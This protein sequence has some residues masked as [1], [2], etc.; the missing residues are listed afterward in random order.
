V[1]SG[2]YGAPV[3]LGDPE[4]DAERFKAASPIAQVHRITRPLLMANGGADLRV[5]LVHGTNRIDFW[6]KVE[7]FL[8][9]HIGGGARWCDNV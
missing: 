4:Q 9:K 3:L 6:T 1:V 5:P 8:G 7:H 2:R